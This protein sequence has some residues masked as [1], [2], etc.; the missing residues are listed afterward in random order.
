L[1]EIASSRADHAF[2]L[3]C[4]GARTAQPKI[5]SPM[6][7]CTGTYEQNPATMSLSI[8]RPYTANRDPRVRTDIVLADLCS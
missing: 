2:K 3:A 1:Y 6:A 7:A 4:R 5:Y 8:D